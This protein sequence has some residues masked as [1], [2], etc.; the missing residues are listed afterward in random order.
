MNVAEL[1]RK[2]SSWAYRYVPGLRQLWARTTSAVIEQ[3]AI[4]WV[5][6]RK[7]LNECRIAIITTGGVHLHE[8]TPFDMQDSHGDP[9]YRVIPAATPHSDL[10]ITHDYYDHRDAERDLNIL[11]PMEHMAALTERG[12][13]GS[14]ADCYSF[15]GHIEGDHL[16]TL[17]QQTAPA[18]SRLLKQQQVDAVLLTPA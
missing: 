4:P 16:T 12:S 8:Q 13:I 2:L 18:V 17:Q 10:E 11:F 1:V 15:M 3:Q 14:L 9:S 7:P 6:L 5:S